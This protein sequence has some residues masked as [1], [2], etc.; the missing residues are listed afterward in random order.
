M[1]IR[2]R[3]RLLE[4]PDELLELGLVALEVVAQSVGAAAGSRC[5]ACSSAVMPH[6]RPRQRERPERRAVNA[7]VDRG[8]APLT[9]AQ[10]LPDLLQR[11]ARLQHRA[12]RGVPQLVASDPRHPGAPAGLAHDRADRMPR[13]SVPPGA[14]TFKNKRPAAVRRGRPAPQIA[15]QRLADIDRQRQRS[16]RPPLP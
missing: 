5:K 3:A 9:V 10:H 2:S 13:T 4:E 7:R 8:R 16:T 1:V 15:H 11:R 12:R 14:I 6:L